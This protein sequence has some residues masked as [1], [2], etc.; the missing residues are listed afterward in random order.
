MSRRIAL[1]YVPTQ[2][3]CG[4]GD[5]QGDELWFPFS[6][7]VHRVLAAIVEAFPDDE[8]KLFRFEPGNPDSSYGELAAFQPDVFGA[9]CFVWSF[10]TLIEVARRL[11]QERPERLIVLGGPCAHPTV[12]DV[13]AYAPFARYVDALVPREGEECIVDVLALSK[14]D[15]AALGALPGVHA[16]GLTGFR[17]SVR[18]SARRPLDALPSPFRNGLYPSGIT[19]HLETFRGCPLSCT[20]CEWGTQ[21]NATRVVS[22]DWLVQ[23]LETFRSLGARAIYCVDAGINLNAKAFRNLVAAENEVHLLRDVAFS[24]MAYADYV[25]PEHVEFLSQIRVHRASVGLQT[26]N[27]EVL[28]RVSRRYDPQKFRDGVTQLAD[29]SEVTVELILGLPGD[30]PESFLRSVHHVLEMDDRLDILVYRCLALPDGLLSRGQEDQSLSFDPT[31]FEVT[32]CLGWSERDL[33]ETRERLERLVE[34]VGGNVGEQWYHLRRRSPHKR[35]AGLPASAPVAREA[36]LEAAGTT[37]RPGGAPAPE[38]VNALAASIRSATRGA[39]NLRDVDLT[40]HGLLVRVH[41]A[42]GELLLDVWEAVPNRPSFR[43]RDG[44][45]WSY[46]GNPAAVAPNLLGLLT[47]TVD[48]SGHLASLLRG[49]IARTAQARQAQL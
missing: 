26:T 46:R 48:G 30:D 6:Y 34:D 24:Y 13:P 40:E 32:A 17:P 19:P 15:R 47:R 49:E 12:F 21:E 8:V 39:W 28:R 23:E 43:V 10:P 36:A 14:P 2:V 35:E 22:K 20:F 5:M 25:R 4:D 33:R 37:P 1:A 18:R 27:Q 16:P 38:I 31:N 41:T 3:P 42:T 44:L 11:K 45:A 29:F 7:G 9:S